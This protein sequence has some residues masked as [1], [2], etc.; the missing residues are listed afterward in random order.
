MINNNRRFLED[1]VVTTIAGGNFGSHQSNDDMPPV[2][3]QPA[4]KI[5]A[6][7]AKNTLYALERGRK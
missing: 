3:E 4:S 6:P 2:V 7:V 1:A 5:L